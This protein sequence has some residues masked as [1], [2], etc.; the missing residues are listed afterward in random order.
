MEMPSRWDFGPN[1]IDA[2]F[3]SSDARA[4]PRFTSNMNSANVDAENTLDSFRY[5]SSMVSVFI[6]IVFKHL[7]IRGCMHSAAKRWDACSL[8]EPSCD[9]Q[10]K[11]RGHEKR[12]RKRV[13]Q[14]TSLVVDSLDRCKQAACSATNFWPEIIFGN[15][16]S[17]G[18]SATKLQLI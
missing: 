3:A 6:A 10:W 14:Y 17:Y 9:W 5:R 15:V 13:I 4:R 7:S 16:V 11:Q 18:K 8:S 2:V 12:M 1:A